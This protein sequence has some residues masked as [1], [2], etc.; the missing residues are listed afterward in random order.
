MCQHCDAVD[1]IDMLLDRQGFD[2]WWYDIE[3]ETQ[4]EIRDEIARII[5]EY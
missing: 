1:I 4:E 3:P 5:G 2:A